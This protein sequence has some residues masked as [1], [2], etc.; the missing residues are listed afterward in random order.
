MTI[1]ESRTDLV[2]WLDDVRPDVHELDLTESLAD[3]LQA[4]D[5]PAWGEDWSEWLDA[6]DAGIAGFLQDCISEAG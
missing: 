2:N 5:H 6:R 3:Y 4:L 1:I